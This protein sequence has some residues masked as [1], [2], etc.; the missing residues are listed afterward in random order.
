MGRALK[1]YCIELE[2]NLEWYS[3]KEY[4]K[5]GTIIWFYHCMNRHKNKWIISYFILP[6]QIACT[7]PQ[8][9]FRKSFPRLLVK[10]MVNYFVKLCKLTL[11]FFLW[12]IWFKRRQEL[13]LFLFLLWWSASY[14]FPAWQ[15]KGNK[16]LL[17]HSSTFQKYDMFKDSL[18]VHFWSVF[19]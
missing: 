16:A 6:V 4:N 9:C 14:F 7:E 11:H 3:L 1:I 19:I 13:L 10:N 8:I 5:R 18:K 17:L 2:S 15:G 12:L